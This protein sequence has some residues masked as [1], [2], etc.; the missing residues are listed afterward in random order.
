MLHRS[1]FIESHSSCPKSK[2]IS[3][4]L[5]HAKPSLR[6]TKVLLWSLVKSDAVVMPVAPAELVENT[7]RLATHDAKFQIF[8]CSCNYV[9]F[10]FLRRFALHPPRVVVSAP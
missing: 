5:P 10:S 1:H 6:R 7:E 8:F 2:T 9:A 4:L 3:F